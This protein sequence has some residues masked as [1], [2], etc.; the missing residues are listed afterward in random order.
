MVRAH[1]LRVSFFRRVAGGC[2]GLAVALAASGCPGGGDGETRF[3]Y[4]PSDSQ[5][6]RANLN[7]DRLA[8]YL[9]RSELHTTG[10]VRDV[11]AAIARG[12]GF[13]QNVRDVRDR[14]TL[15]TVFLDRGNQLHVVTR[16]EETCPECNG[17]GQRKVGLA[18]LES[19][20][21][22][23][24]LKCEGKKTLANHVVEKRYVLS[25]EDYADVEGARRFIHD[26][27]YRG[28]PPETERYVAALGSDDPRERLAACVWLDQHWVRTGV[29]FTTYQPLLDK[30]RRHEQDEGKQLM[31]WRL[32]AGRDLP[33]EEGRAYYD[34]HANLRSGKIIRKGFSAAR[35]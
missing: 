7:P 30:A 8:D 18:T 11:H 28:A 24:C 34:V 5:L 16:R 27:F 15:A 23:R 31:V 33:G 17:T 2:L 6:A 26:T 13:R 14:P 19:K 21:S 20:M 35:P 25:A 1:R 22:F 9:A 32:W 12:E 10:M 29:A 3:S 4:K